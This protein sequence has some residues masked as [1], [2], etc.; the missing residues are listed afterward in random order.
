MTSTLLKG[1]LLAAAAVLAGPLQAAADGVQ[2][3]QRMTSGGTTD[4]F[5]IQIDASHM[6]METTGPTGQKQTVIFDG[7]RQVLWMIDASR[8]TYNEMTKAD[9]DRMGGQISDAM[10]Q[11]QQQMANMPPEARAQMEAMMRGRG[12]PGAPPRTE[13]RRAGSDRVGT[14]ACDKYD[15]VRNG[16]KA[17]EICTVAP[18]ALGF[19][20]ADFAVTRQLADFFQRLMPQGADRMFAI[21]TE[22]A[23]GYNGV[24]VKHVTMEGQRQTVIEVTEAGRQAFPASTFE[25]P[26]GYKKEDFM[27]PGGR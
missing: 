22:Q 21:G 5:R 12:M 7:A 23:Q 3:V 19:T 4:T 2:I 15:I 25:V 14:W 10:A 6:R 18:S 24:P 20:P 11:M 26:A 16:Q 9:V 17:G 13:Y 27:N 8:R 1:V